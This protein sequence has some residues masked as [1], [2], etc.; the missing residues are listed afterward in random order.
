MAGATVKDVVAGAQADWA[1][2]ELEVVLTALLEH[3]V[4]GYERAR[5]WV[6]RGFDVTNTA[7]ESQA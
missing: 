5:G 3:G 4:E 6:F 7:P 1:D 2:R